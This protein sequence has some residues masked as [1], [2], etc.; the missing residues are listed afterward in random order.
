MST[1]RSIVNP[2]SLANPGAAEWFAAEA[3]RYRSDN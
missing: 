1:R 3:G 2:A